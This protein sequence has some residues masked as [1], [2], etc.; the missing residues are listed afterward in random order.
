MS[1]VK[2]NDRDILECACDNAADIQVILEKIHSE[3][4]VPEDILVELSYKM[5]YQDYLYDCHGRRKFRKSKII[6]YKQY[7]N[8]LSMVNR[9]RKL[10]DI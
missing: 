5:F 7:R 3:Y 6:P 4:G 10:F 8:S 1:F 2:M 9:M